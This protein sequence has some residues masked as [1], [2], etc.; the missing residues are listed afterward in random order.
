MADTTNFDFLGEHDPLF[1]QLAASAERGF[2]S[3][4]NKRLL[5]LRRPEWSNGIKSFA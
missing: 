3:D 1:H 4:P 5:L 2:V